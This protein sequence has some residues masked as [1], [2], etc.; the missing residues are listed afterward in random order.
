MK[1]FDKLLLKA[2]AHSICKVFGLIYQIG[3]LEGVLFKIKY[4]LITSIKPP[5]AD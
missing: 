3:Q 5:K 4:P 1:N 2:V